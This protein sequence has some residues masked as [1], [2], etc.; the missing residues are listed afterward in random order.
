MMEIEIKVSEIKFIYS[1]NPNFSKLKSIKSL[2][3]KNFCFVS[4]P[5]KL[6]QYYREF[7]F[8]EIKYG[9]LEIKLGF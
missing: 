3:S 1:K 5:E 2:K 7:D 6:A 4:L 8:T 9:F